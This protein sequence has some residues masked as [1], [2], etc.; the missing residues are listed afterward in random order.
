MMPTTPAG[1]EIH[2]SKDGLAVDLYIE[3]SLPEVTGDLLTDATTAEGLAHEKV[4]ELLGADPNDLTWETGSI[5]VDYEAA[6][7]E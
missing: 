5:N 3:L 2:L 7:C 6:S 1:V 4:R